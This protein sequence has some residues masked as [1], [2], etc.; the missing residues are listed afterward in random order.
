MDDLNQHILKK[1]K[2]PLE[3]IEASLRL[4]NDLFLIQ[5]QKKWYLVEEEVNVTTR[6][7][8]KKEVSTILKTSKFTE[9]TESLANM[10]IFSFI[11]YFCFKNQK[12][13]NLDEFWTDAGI[14]ILK[15]L[16][17]ISK[18][19][20]E[21]YIAHYYFVSETIGEK[22]MFAVIT[23]EYNKQYTDDIREAISVEN[24]MSSSWGSFSSKNKDSF[25]RFFTIL[26]SIKEDIENDVAIYWFNKDNQK[27]EQLTILETVTYEEMQA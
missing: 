27:K 12:K 7:Y 9:L 18:E 17:I 13:K 14:E 23:E 10:G 21:E 5:Q 1:N 25:D 20:E 2:S 3:K 22:E 11:H 15:D 6:L 19:E 26:K 4:R 8:S 16:L 24:Y